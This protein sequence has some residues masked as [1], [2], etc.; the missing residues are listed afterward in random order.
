MDRESATVCLDKAESIW[1]TAYMSAPSHPE[2][3]RELRRRVM[4]FLNVSQ[5]SLEE[6]AD[7]K[8][9]VGKACANALRHGSPRG[10]LDEI[11]VKCVRSERALIV[12]VSDN[13]Y[14]FDPDSVPLPMF[15]GLSEGGMGIF[16]MRTLVDSVE[17]RFGAGTIVQLIKR[18]LREG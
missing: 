12:E 16:L 10:E 1:E 13:G 14:G 2:N 8:L 9:A 3:V 5:L 7:L 6:A 17:F 4:E 18:C 11:R 15:S